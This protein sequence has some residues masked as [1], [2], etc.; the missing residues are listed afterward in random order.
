MSYFSGKRAVIT[1]AGSGI[2]RALAHQLS[3]A[4]CELWLADVDAAALADTRRGLGGPAACHTAVVDVADRAAMSAWA[5]EVSRNAPQL[6]LV[7]NN[8]G[9]GLIGTAQ[10]TTLEDFDWLMGVNFWGVVH[11]C[12][13]FL[14]LLERAPRS[15]LVNISSIFGIIGVPT[16]SAYNASKFA[17]RGYSEALRQELILAG[18][19][20]E[21]C[22]VHPG[23]IDTNIARRARSSD[24]GVVGQG[25]GRGRARHHPARL[26]VRPAPRPAGASGSAPCPRRRG[27]R[28]GPGGS[29]CCSSSRPAR[30]APPPAP[31]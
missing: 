6:E 24:R 31:P 28:A 26:R 19:P 12:R 3:G 10:D 17:V 27:R 5:D 25:R 7:V 8:A 14:P 20:V 11:G 16:Q 4:G 23:G 1:G 18:S 15:H 2:G 9:V 21:V 30:A 13:V 29:P 22:C